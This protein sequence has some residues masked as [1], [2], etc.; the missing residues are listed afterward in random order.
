M[1]LWLSLLFITIII[2]KFQS[3]QLQAS[4]TVLWPVGVFYAII[5]YYQVGGS[6]WSMGQTHRFNMIVFNYNNDND[7]TAIGFYYS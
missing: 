2:G 7:I 5:F 1:F 6:M 3:P 4:C